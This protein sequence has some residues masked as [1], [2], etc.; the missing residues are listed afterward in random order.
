VT[1]RLASQL[2][3]GSRAAHTLTV[4]LLVLVGVVIGRCCA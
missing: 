3:L 4:L 2:G 1:D